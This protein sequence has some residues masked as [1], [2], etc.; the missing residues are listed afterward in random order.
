M[1]TTLSLVRCF[2]N[3]ISNNNELKLMNQLLNL[4]FTLVCWLAG[5]VM[6][7]I[8]LHSGILFKEGRGSSLPRLM[9][10]EVCV[11]TLGNMLNTG[12]SW[13]VSIA[14]VKKKKK[15]ELFKK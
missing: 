5:G 10:L 15:I 13:V 1:L 9:S 8:Y 12:L 2:P 3:D 14:L 11:R 4:E 6:S 7:L